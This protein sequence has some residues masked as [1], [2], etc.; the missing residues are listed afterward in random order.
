M[1]HL[2]MWAL[3]QLSKAQ[4]VDSQLKMWTAQ[5]LR[6]YDF[7]NGRVFYDIECSWQEGPGPEPGTYNLTSIHQQNE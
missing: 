4:F 6:D 1:C 5:R 7:C 2:Q 3:L